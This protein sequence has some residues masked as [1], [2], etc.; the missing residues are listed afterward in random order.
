MYP[1]SGLFYDIIDDRFMVVV[2]NDLID[3]SMDMYDIIAGQS[4]DR[5]KFILDGCS[6]IFVCEFEHEIDLVL[7]GVTFV[8]FAED[9]EFVWSSFFDDLELIKIDTFQSS[10]LISLLS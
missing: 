2:G 5:F 7:W 3:F 4:G 8:W 6:W 10:E 9:I 1:I